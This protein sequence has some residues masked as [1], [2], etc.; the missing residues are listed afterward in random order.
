MSKDDL[1]LRIVQELL[2]NTAADVEQIL[3][4]AEKIYQWIKK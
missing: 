2:R 1:K 3:E 4:A